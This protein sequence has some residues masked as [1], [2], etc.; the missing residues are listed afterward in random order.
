[1]LQNYVD[2]TGDIQ[3][4][5][6]LNLHS[7]AHEVSKDA[8]MA[9]WINSYRSLLDSWRLWTQRAKFDVQF[10]KGHGSGAEKSPQQVYVSCNFCGKSVSV[11]LGIKG[12]MPLGRPNPNLRSKVNF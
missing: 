10:Y 3:T 4:V 8:R 1:M 9:Q 5:S 11:Y 12:R 6:L 7:A 2:R